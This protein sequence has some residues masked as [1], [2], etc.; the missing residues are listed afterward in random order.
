MNE[1]KKKIANF[2]LELKSEKEKLKRRPTSLRISFLN[3]TLNIQPHRLVLFV[4]GDIFGI[5]YNNS[6]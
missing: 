1:A 3:Q 4:F 2:I 5:F 6:N